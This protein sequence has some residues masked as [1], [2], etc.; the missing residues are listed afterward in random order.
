M[1]RNELRILRA[2]AALCENMF[3]ARRQKNGSIV[4]KDIISIS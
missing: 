1:I 3:H 2:F 4:G